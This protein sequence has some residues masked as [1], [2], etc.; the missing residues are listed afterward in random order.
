MMRRFSFFG[1]GLLVVLFASGCEDHKASTPT[2]PEASQEVPPVISEFVKKVLDSHGQPS[3]DDLHTYFGL[4]DI[5]E[6]SLLW[7]LCDS[8][9]QAAVLRDQSCVNKIIQHWA[10]RKESQSLYLQWL[11][12]QLPS[13]PTITIKSISAQVQAESHDGRIQVPGQRVVAM[14]NDSEVEFWIPTNSASDAST[15]KLSMVAINGTPVE[16]LRRKAANTSI[17][18]AMGFKALLQPPTPEDVAEQQRQYE[19]SCSKNP[20]CA[21]RREA[22]KKQEAT[23]EA[24]RKQ[25]QQNYD[26]WCKTNAD[27][28]RKQRTDGQKMIDKLKA[29]DESCDGDYAACVK[30]AA[31]LIKEQRA[32]R[33]DFCAAFPQDCATQ[34]E[35]LKQSD[36]R[37]AEQC[38]K[39]PQLCAGEKKGLGS[40]MREAR[41]RL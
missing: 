7:R 14:L 29:L 35:A 17:L 24:A 30:Q 22:L 8:S 36:A 37:Y 5:D 31:V 34:D 32:I 16:I 26:T 20:Q 13:D 9:G 23:Q 15:G 2:V 25:N 1:L 10:N 11:K 4:N 6:F 38:K 18:V 39:N 41:A 27:E 28:C 40:A 19:E 21:Q 3:V 33:A 12:Q